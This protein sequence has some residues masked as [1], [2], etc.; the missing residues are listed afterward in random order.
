MSL[1]PK[2]MEIIGKND[3]RRL[4]L[5][6]VDNQTQHLVITVKKTETKAT[7]KKKTVT[8]PEN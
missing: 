4:E 8:F 2:N 6:P 3:D 5:H 1:S 7:R